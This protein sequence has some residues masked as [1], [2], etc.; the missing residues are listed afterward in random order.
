MTKV[1]SLSI[2]IPVFNEEDYIGACLDAIAAQSVLPDEVIVV[3]NNSTDAT[4]DIVNRYDFVTVISEKRQGVVYARDTG[5]DCVT[6]DLI[7]RIDADTILP[8]S[9][10]KTVLNIMFDD[11]IFAATGPVS[12]YDMPSPKTNYKIDHLIRKNLY[13]GAPHVPFLFG[14]NMV[15]R[16]D[17]W[18]SLRDE[19]CR[20]KELHEDLDL[21]VHMMQQHRPICYR[22]EMLASTS[23]R[24]Y[25]DDVVSFAHYMGVYRKTYSIHS[26]YS[27]APIIATGFYWIGYLTLYPLRRSYD[28]VTNQR[29]LKNLLK[30][31]EARPHPM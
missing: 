24:R 28:P 21:A 31:S 19:V 27:I 2:I 10:V 17:A 5:F 13:R 6:S 11:T 30:K 29:S 23:S 26:I 14:S 1:K 22:S 4:L 8:K 9:W 3:D 18:Q 16:K 12:Y 25:D 15:I 20:S 7:G